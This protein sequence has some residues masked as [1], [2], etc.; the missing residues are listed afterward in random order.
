MMVYWYMDQ[1]LSY[2]MIHLQMYLLQRRLPAQLMQENL[3]KLHP[4]TPLLQ[5]F[6]LLIQLYFHM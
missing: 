6:H 3:L 1:E 5:Q 2:L 4:Q